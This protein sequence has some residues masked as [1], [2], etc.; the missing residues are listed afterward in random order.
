M[1]KRKVITIG[2]NTE[3][4]TFRIGDQTLDETNTYKYLGMTINN[5]GNLQD[6]LE[7]TKGKVEAALQT[8]F[9]IARN[10]NF[11]N[12]EM[13][14]IWKLVNSC[15]I[16]ILMYGAETW[17]PTKA[18]TTSIQKMLNNVITRILQIPR[19]TATEILTTETGILD[20]ETQMN[21]KQIAY[22]HRINTTLKNSNTGIMA[23][24]SNNTWNKQVKLNMNKV[25]IDEATLLQT[26]NPKNYITQK[27]RKYQ[28]NKIL[29][30]AEK[31]SKVRDL[32]I[33]KDPSNLTTRPNYMNGLTRNECS[34]IMLIRSRMLQ[35]KGNYKNNYNDMKC[36]WCHAAIE[37]QKHILTSCREFTEITDNT[38]YS[39]YF[40]EDPNKLK[41]ILKAL[42]K[43]QDK[44][45]EKS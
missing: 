40:S 24:N 31:K 25:G 43:I 28:N 21:H 16:P 9:C 5:K 22:Y 13:K 14:V 3:G 15:I 11:I 10:N 2:K 17:T 4:H 41:P 37:T 39:S 18:E 23:T 19:T 45:K 6:H 34:K 8:I 27:I 12:M 29:E 42:D 32:I 38:T 36:R 44:L 33:H 30:A 20:I 7:K 1:G 35:I 26:K